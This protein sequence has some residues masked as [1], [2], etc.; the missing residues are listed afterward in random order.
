M[1]LRALRA[2]LAGCGALAIASPS[3]AALLTPLATTGHDQDVVFES[4]LAA[5]AVGANGE[6]GTR[7]FF[8]D[9]ATS[10]TDDGLP[11]V[12]PTFA[13][14]VTG[15]AISFKFAPF[16]GNNIVKLDSTT[17]LGVIKTLT[18]TIPVPVSN[19]AV[20]FTGGSLSGTSAP[21]AGFTPRLG[22]TVNYAGGA[23]QTAEFIV[24]D[25]GNGALPAGII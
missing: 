22:V 8:E 23:T 2:L 19:L 14:P 11:P 24:P 15:N 13:S 9:G 1:R 20:I 6:I 10:A 4:G 16:S 7:Q 21:P 25:W 12:L 3:L 5:A 17:P 18:L